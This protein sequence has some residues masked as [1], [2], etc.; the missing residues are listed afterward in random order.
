MPALLMRTSTGPR[1]ASTFL[2]PVAQAL[3]NKKVGDSVDYEVHGTRH[4][5][6]IDAIEAYNKAIEEAP[7][8]Q[9]A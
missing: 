1:S 6:R 5:H 7:V 3:L 4:H 9:Q 8:A 2:T